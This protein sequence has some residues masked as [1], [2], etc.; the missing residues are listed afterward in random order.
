MIPPIGREG[1]PLAIGFELIR[2]LGNIVC[3]E[4]SHHLFYFVRTIIIT[5]RKHISKLAIIRIS[6]ARLAWIGSEARACRLVGDTSGRN[7]ELV[8]RTDVDILPSSL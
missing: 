7:L 4:L 2:I 3:P 6:G 8:G 1:K 5:V